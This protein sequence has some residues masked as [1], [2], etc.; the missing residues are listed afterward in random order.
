M[1]SKF[2]ALVRYKLNPLIVPRPDVKWEEKGTLNP[3][4]VFE[5]DMFHLFY[6]GVAADGVSSIGYA[7]FTKRM[8]NIERAKIPS[9]EPCNDWE[10]LRCEDPR[11]TKIGDTYYLLYTAYSPLGP[12]IALASSSDLRKFNRFGV[13]GPDVS[14]KDAVFFPELIDGK[15]VMIHRIEPSMQIAYFDPEQV[16]S[17]DVQ[18]RSQYWSH[19]LSHVDEH[20]LMKP[21]Q[22]WEKGK[23][24]AGPPPIKTN[25]GWL[26]IYHGVD[27]SRIY[28]AGVALVDLDKPSKILARSKMPILEPEEPFEIH[29][30]V[31]RVVFPEA[32]MVVD[33]TLHVFY[34]AADSVC[35]VATAPISEIELLMQRS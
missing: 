29:G 17:R 21:E 6:R 33:K 20:V 25:E 23:I 14:D 7:T 19:Y 9:L 10:R 22:W 26:I 28:R 15:L 30:A 12:R 27:D 13:I 1:H 34:G 8:K 31:N 2:P 32:A 11:I 16:K 24:G 5:D 18:A 4:G 35:C 3:G